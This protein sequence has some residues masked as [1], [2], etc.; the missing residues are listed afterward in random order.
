M[1]IT[2]GSIFVHY[3]TVQAECYLLS[4]I[5]TIIDDH[6]RQAISLVKLVNHILSFRLK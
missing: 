4:L 6:P 3:P 1:A 2:G 5:F